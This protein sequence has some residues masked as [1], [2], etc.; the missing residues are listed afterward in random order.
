LQVTRLFAVN[1]TSNPPFTQMNDQNFEFYLPDGATVDQAWA[2]T[3]GG[4][5]VNSSPVPEKEKNR[6]SFIFPLRPGETRFQIAFHIPY[7]GRSIISCR[8]LY[9][10][11]HFVVILPATMQFAQPGSAFQQ[12]KDEGQ[13]NALVEVVSNTSVGQNLNFSISGTGT[14]PQPGKGNQGTSGSGDAVSSAD[15]RPGGGL[16]PP[17]DSPDPL[18]KFRLYIL[19]GLGLALTAG[20]LVVRAKRVPVASSALLMIESSERSP[21]PAMATEQ[22]SAVLV[23]LKEELFRLEVE[24]KQGRISQPEYQKAKTALDQVLARVLR[25]EIVNGNLAHP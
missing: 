20:V 18:E 6:Y 15:V 3:A 24:H 8:G 11:Q 10:S 19:A 9:A 16:G 13:S 23:G 25:R 5:P 22:A 17:T 12:I 2:I 1:N 21:G 7:T 4:Q 14:L